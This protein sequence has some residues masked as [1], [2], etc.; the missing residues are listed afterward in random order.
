MYAHHSHLICGVV[1]EKHLFITVLLTVIIIVWTAVHFSAVYRRHG[2]VIRYA[3]AVV[4]EFCLEVLVKEFEVYPLFQ[5]F[6]RR[7]VEYVH[8]HLVKQSFLIHIAVS[9]HLLH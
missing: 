7:T 9:H 4:D 3:Y 2:E 8:H 5:R 1:A 6:F